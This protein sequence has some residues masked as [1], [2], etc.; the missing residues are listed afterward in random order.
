MNEKELEIL[1]KSNAFMDST[2]DFNKV[3]EKYITKKEEGSY[4]TERKGGVKIFV[5]VTS[6]CLVLILGWVFISKYSLITKKEKIEKGEAIIVSVVVG[7]VFAKKVGSANWKKINVEEILQMGDYLK[8]DKDSFCELQ[9]VKRGVF[10]IEPS[11]E[12]HLATLVNVNNNIHSKFKLEK[13]ALGLKPKKLKTGEVFEVHT[14]SAVA[15][16]RGTK[17][18]VS[19]DETGNTKVSVVE[20]KV[21]V[22]PSISSIEKAKEAGVIDEKA[23]EVIKEKI[24]KPVEVLAGEEVDLKKEKIEKVDKVIGETIKNLAEEKG[25][26]TIESQTPESDVKVENITAKIEE[27]ISKS[28]TEK[29]APKETENVMNLIVEKKEVTPEIQKKLDLISEEKVIEKSETIKVIFKTTPEGANIYIDGK[30]AGVTPLEMVF[31]KDKKFDVKIEKEGFEAFSKE[32]VASGNINVEAIL[33]QK[34]QEMVAASSEVS[35]EVSSI[36][37]VSGS[38][39]WEKQLTGRVKSFEHN[40]VVYKD[41]IFA[42][43]SDRLIIYSLDGKLYKNIKVGENVQLTKIALAKDMI[44]VGADSKGIYTYSFDGKL[45]W[46]NENVGGQK[47]GGHPVVY[48]DKI[49]VTSF[50]QGISILNLK[51]EV[52]DTIVVPSQ[53]YSSPLILKGGKQL[54]YALENGNIVCYDI[55]GKKVLWS[56][57]YE[58]RILYP[59]VGNEEVVIVLIRNNGVVKAYSTLDG[60]KKWELSIP[61]LQKTDID[62]VYHN[63]YVILGKSGENSI[64]SIV[65]ATSGKLVNSF[66]F[67]ERVSHPYLW[68]D[69]LF[70]GTA[71]GKVYAY[72]IK[73]NKTIW[74]SETGKKGLIS[75][76]VNDD[77]VFGI[78]KTSML[79]IVK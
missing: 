37:K 23:A 64:I 44:V 73:N 35:S 65:N 68:G 50:E 30:L 16:V 45:L 69:N 42:V 61:E 48:K 13:G 40:Q 18:L 25:K 63:G 74:V 26:I 27:K 56:R 70:F 43:S 17:F 49:Y 29:S 62:P 3:W 71:S 5:W 59:L 2:P 60:S 72:D 67:T 58:D 77:G 33:N 11:S 66:K 15:A 36:G 31:E 14:E 21:S 19:V 46:K 39:E 52:I 32:Y 47:F 4:M 12:L 38:L 10:R 41:R 24:V 8:T 53:I 75:V 78:S 7:D 54:I 1:F 20:G 51:G 34:V 22:K 79:K 55:E 57:S 6:F 76:V 28:L 9:M